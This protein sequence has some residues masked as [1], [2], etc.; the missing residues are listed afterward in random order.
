M[1]EG[2]PN[3]KKRR[4]SRK[5]DLQVVVEDETFHVHSRDLMA[6]SEVF[7]QML[8]SDMREGEEG[9]ITLAGK[10]KEEFR[11]LLTHLVPVRGAAL[12]IITEENV[13]VL[14]KWADEYQIE[15]LTGRCQTYLVSSVSH[16][17]A[18]KRT[19]TVVQ[20]M[21][22]ASEYRLEDLEEYCTDIICQNV[23]EYRNDLLQFAGSGTFLLRKAL[24]QLFKAAGITELPTSSASN[25]VELQD[26]WPLVCRALEAMRGWKSNCDKQR[27]AEHYETVLQQVLDGIRNHSGMP[28]SRQELSKKVSQKAGQGMTDIIIDGLLQA[29]TIRECGLFGPGRYRMS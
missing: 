14:L 12:P 3:A 21:H 26:V 17:P 24:P 9:Q 25:T 19:E 6:A 13:F 10:S 22:V 8:E 4:F 5:P 2:E 15:G 23:F 11:T 28:P 16:L 20:R 29:E 7:E 18:E 1:A 27:V